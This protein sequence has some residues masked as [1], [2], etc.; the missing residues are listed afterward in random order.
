MILVTGAAGF[1]GFHLANKLLAHGYRVAGVDDLNDYY[2]TS[3]KEYRIAK[4]RTSSNFE[5][6]S[7]DV[8]DPEAVEE[9]FRSYEPT[10]V[11]HLAAQAGVQYSIS[12]PHVYLHSNM[13]G[14]L[15]ICE[16]SA[17]FQVK[18]LIYASSSSVYG[19]NT[20]IPFSESQRTGKPVS[21]YAATKIAN[22]ATAHSYSHLYNLRTTGLRF[23]TV[24]G[25]AGRPDMAYWKFTEAIV[26]GDPIYLFFHGKARRDFTYIDDVVQAI[27]CMIEKSIAPESVN[28]QLPLASV[29]NIG[30]HTPVTLLEFVRELETAIGIKAKI[31]LSPPKPGDV[32]V[33]Y[34]DVSDL[35]RDYGFAPDTPLN[36][37]IGRFVDWYLHEW[38]PHK[39]R[40]TESH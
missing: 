10:I 19:A 1:I 31:H 3:L 11:V 9:M 26:S 32:E 30:N 40:T 15:N 12:N 28:S 6:T 36:Q 2:D 18:H 20:Q 22:E 34:A 37:G 27:Y 14:F 8:G 38:L 13:L 16:S 39:L 5:F 21:F 29:Y 33:T 7:M 17:K 4:L 25:P 35:Q 23:F 24:Y